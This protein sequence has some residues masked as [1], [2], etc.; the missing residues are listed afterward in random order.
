[1]AGLVSSSGTAHVSG[2]DFPHS[3]RPDP[4]CLTTPFQGIDLAPPPPG[5]FFHRGGFLNP[6][7]HLSLLVISPIS[8]KTTSEL[9]N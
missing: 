2:V 9:D 3:G 7:A 8:G 6:K 5:G 1:M 4:G